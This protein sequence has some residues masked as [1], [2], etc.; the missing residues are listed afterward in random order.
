MFLK[1]IAIDYHGNLMKPGMKSSCRHHTERVSSGNWCHRVPG[2]LPFTDF[3]H[4]LCQCAIC[5]PVVNPLFKPYSASVASVIQQVKT[6]L[7]PTFT[8]GIEIRRF[9]MRMSLTASKPNKLITTGFPCF[10]SVRQP[11]LMTVS[12]SRPDIL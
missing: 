8:S 5:L 1:L 2:I 9:S 4:F 7:P 10:N 12:S 3:M 11:C 6:K